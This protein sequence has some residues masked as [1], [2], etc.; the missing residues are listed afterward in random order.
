[1][2]K[3][4]ILAT[5]LLFSTMASGDG[6]RIK[7]KKVKAELTPIQKKKRAKNKRA[8]KNRKKNRK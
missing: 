5:A 7:S 6:I 3:S 2:N 1:M 8:K 4:K